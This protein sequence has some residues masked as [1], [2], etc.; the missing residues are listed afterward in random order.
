MGEAACAGLEPLERH[1]APEAAECPIRS[2]TR[3]PAEVGPLTWPDLTVQLARNL[4]R[5]RVPRTTIQRAPTVTRHA[6]RD[7]CVDPFAFCRLPEL[8]RP[9]E[10]A[11]WG[12]PVA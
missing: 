5:K 8:V 7:T 4:R 6:S 1:A 3:L 10:R 9:G 12:R 2:R 11:I